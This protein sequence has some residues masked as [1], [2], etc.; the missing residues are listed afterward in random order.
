[1]I[2]HIKF[3]Q[4]HILNRTLSFGRTGLQVLSSLSFF[5]DY[6][7]VSIYL[8]FYPSLDPALSGLTKCHAE[9]QL[10]FHAV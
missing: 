1:M 2:M 5:G 3:T 10:L 9:S 8:L 7:S 6:F 4:E